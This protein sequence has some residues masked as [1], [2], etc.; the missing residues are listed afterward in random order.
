MYFNFNFNFCFCF[1]FLFLF[2]NANRAIEQRITNWQAG[3]QANWNSL[4][5]LYTSNYTRVSMYRI[6]S[7]C[8]LYMW[9]LRQQFKYPHTHTHSYPLWIFLFFC[10]SHR[11]RDLLVVATQLHMFLVCRSARTPYIYLSMD[12]YQ[13][14]VACNTHSLYLV[15]NGQLIN[16]TN[17]YIYRHTQVQT[18]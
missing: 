17:W 6:V 9:I 13:A 16:S 7:Y 15:S 5:S 2:S 11:H 3:R 18:D 8:I 10:L 14:L 1:L 12:S 4:P